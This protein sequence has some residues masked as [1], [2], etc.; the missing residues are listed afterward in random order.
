MTRVRSTVLTTGIAALRERGH[1]EAYEAALDPHA[2]DIL[3]TTVAGVWLPIDLAMTHY[4]ACESLGLS[5]DETFAIGSA[6]ATR[7]HENILHLIRH[8]AA[9]IGATPW[10]AGAR[11]DAFWTRAFDGGG[12]RLTKVGP[13]DGLGEYFQIPMA[14]FAYFRSAFCGVSLAGI[15]LFTPKAYVRVV[16]TSKDGFSIR[17]SWV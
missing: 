8:L 15:S 9:G 3:L 13:K 16:S 7:M 5:H 6:V 11:Y 17:S 12:F 1:I 2:R 10:T 14:Q 4:R